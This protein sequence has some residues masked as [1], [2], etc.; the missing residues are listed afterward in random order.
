MK[1]V[2]LTDNTMWFGLF[3][4]S[5]IL[6]L[7][8]SELENYRIYK[9]FYVVGILWSFLG[10]CVL[11]YLTKTPNNIKLI[12]VRSASYTL[13]WLL[14][15]VPWGIIIGGTIGRYFDNPSWEATVHT[16]LYLM[17]PAIIS[18]FFIEDFT[19]LPKFKFAKTEKFRIAFLGGYFILA[20]LGLQL[21]G[22]VFDLIEFNG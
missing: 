8:L 12:I 11:S 15:Y 7:Y 2:K 18:V 3:L 19:E 5:P 13:K 9:L 16:G 10:V 4:F 14:F 20:G 17:F 6:G 22:A 1:L 21:T